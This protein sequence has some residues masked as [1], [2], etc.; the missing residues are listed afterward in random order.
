[1]SAR[2]LWAE[3]PAAVPMRRMNP[4]AHLRKHIFKLS[5][6]D[7]AKAIGVNQSTVS[8]WEAGGLEPSRSEMEAIRRLAA[9][10]QIEWQDRWFFEVPEA[11]A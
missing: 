11:A 8:R 4:L 3:P 6:L 10:R 2:I 7:F 1:M 5:Q 9:E